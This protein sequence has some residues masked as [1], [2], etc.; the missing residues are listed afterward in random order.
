[1]GGLLLF[2]ALHEERTTFVTGEHSLLYWARKSGILLGKNAGD[3]RSSY[4]EPPEIILI[5]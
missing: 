5:T 2:R 4:L 3:V 1:M